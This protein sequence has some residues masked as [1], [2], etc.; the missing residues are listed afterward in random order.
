[1]TCEKCGSSNLRLSRHERWTDQFQRVIGR[2][3]VRCRNCRRRFYVSRNSPLAKELAGRDGERTSASPA[4]RAQRRRR[5]AKRLIVIAVFAVA[6]ALFWFF[7][8]YMTTERVP[9][10]ESGSISSP[11]YSLA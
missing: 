10:E 4:S 3:A 2:E 5:M 9:S 1:M 7:L 6:F 11:P 8:R